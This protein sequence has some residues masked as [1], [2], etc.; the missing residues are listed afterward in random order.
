ML[1]LDPL[2]FDSTAIF[3]LCWNAGADADR[4]L[5][6]V[7]K[8][9]PRLMEY[10]GYLIRTGRVDA[11]MRA[12]PEALALA[13]ASNPQDAALLVPYCAFLV[14]AG[15]IGDAVN[16]WNGLVAKSFVRGKALDPGRGVSIADPGFAFPLSTAAFSWQAATAAGL[17]VR[18]LSPHLQFELDGQESES[19][20]LLTAAA[21][22]LPAR[23]YRL[24]WKADASRLAA[25][26]DPGFAFHIAQ[27]QDAAEIQCALLANPA[28][29]TFTT[30]AGV[31]LL[32]IT[33]SYARAPGTVR[34][35]GDLR[36]LSTSLEFVP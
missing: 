14:N 6:L 31:E 32:R 22:V 17:F 29:C 11:A 18:Q 13:D 36:L 27:G 10:L 4:I 19:L 16:A 3:D 33:L 12:W 5:A 24:A 20:G 1:R 34:A 23:K 9:R 7:P 21:P 26:D 15:R 25:P 8:K 28:P 35:K 2:G 30:R